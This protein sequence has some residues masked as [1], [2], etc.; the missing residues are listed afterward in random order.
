MAY[1]LGLSTNCKTQKIVKKEYGSLDILLLETTLASMTTPT[2][3]IKLLIDIL[4][5][6]PLNSLVILT[7]K[8]MQIESMY[9]NTY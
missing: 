7:S 2:T 4:I 3:T 8:L 5:S 6:F 9:V 1:S